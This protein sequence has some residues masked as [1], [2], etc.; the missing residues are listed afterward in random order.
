[1]I[2]I[3]VT[4]INVFKSQE[5]KEKFLGL[6]MTLHTPLNVLVYVIPM[7]IKNSI[8]PY[9][10]WVMIENIKPLSVPSTLQIITS[11]NPFLWNWY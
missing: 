9:R 11:A 2:S 4:H 6:N 5:A 7:R 3:N 1:M 8:F 10:I